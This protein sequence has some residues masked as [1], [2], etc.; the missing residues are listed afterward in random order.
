MLAALIVALSNRVVPAH[1]THVTA[2]VSHSDKIGHFLIFGLLATLLARVRAFQRWTPLGA[3][4]A[5][6]L[7]SLFGGTDE[8]HQML[9]QGRSADVYDWAADT[10]GA[11]VFVAAYA[12]SATYRQAL[13]A[14][15]VP[16]G[17]KRQGDKGMACIPALGRAIS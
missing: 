10:L 14:R 11:A 12:G 6:V 4:M 7:V 15:V 5:V 17:R 13:E 9:V 3:Y 2:H 16:V 8:L 1:V